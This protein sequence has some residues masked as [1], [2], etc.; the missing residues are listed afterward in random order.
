MNMKTKQEMIFEGAKFGDKFRTRDGRM[1]VL[2]SQTLSKYGFVLISDHISD[3]TYNCVYETDW[4]GEVYHE[5]EKGT[6]FLDII[7][8]WEEPISEE[9]LYS[10]AKQEEIRLVSCN[11]LN[12]LTQRNKIHADLY[13]VYD[14]MRKMYIAGY[15]KAKEE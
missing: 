9:E 3:S 14:L 2:C 4:F 5:L 12:L 10:L 1:A 15:R 11:G 6:D 8:K 13:N 7:G